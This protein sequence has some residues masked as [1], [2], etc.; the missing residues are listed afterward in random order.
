MMLLEQETLF[1]GKAI[2]IAVGEKWLGQPFPHFPIT[3]NPD[4]LSS[5]T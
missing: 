1:R 5:E 3:E 2:W 4:V